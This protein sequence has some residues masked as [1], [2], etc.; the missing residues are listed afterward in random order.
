MSQPSTSPGDTRAHRLQ[1]TVQP[2]LDSAAQLSPATLHQRPGA[3][4][5]AVSEILAHLAEL[6]SYWADQAHEVA[7]RAENNLP[8][9]RTHDDAARIAAVQDHAQDPLDQLVPRVRSGLEHATTVLR[10]IPDAA[11]QKTGQHVR[12][13]EMTIEEII[14][15]FLVDHVEEHAVQARDAL[16]R[17]GKTH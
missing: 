3:D 15:Q 10:S 8:F 9:G 12:R 7:S 6:L 1:E 5:W 2:V 4:D 13:G 16:D 17:L 14:D 11:W